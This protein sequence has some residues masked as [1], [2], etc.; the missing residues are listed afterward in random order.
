MKNKNYTKKRLLFFLV[1]IA[2]IFISVSLFIIIKTNTIRTEIEQGARS[3]GTTSY[4]TTKSTKLIDLI[5]SKKKVSLEEALSELQNEKFN[6]NN[7]LES[8]RLR[9][10][11]N[12]L[13]PSFKITNKSLE[14]TITDELT[15]IINLSR[16][17]T[18]IKRRYLG[19]KSVELGNYWITTYT[20]IGVACLL[21]ILL[22]FLGLSVFKVQQKIQ[23]LTNQ[24]IEFL[25][26]S[27]DAIIAC[28]INGNIKEFNPASEQTFGYK[29]NEVINQPVKILYSSEKEHNRVFKTIQETGYFNGEIINKRSNNETIVSNL[30]ANLIYDQKGKVMGSMGVS[31]DV[32]A[33]KKLEEEHQQIINSASDIIY[34]AN[35]KGVFTY[36]NPTVTKILGYT[37]E[38]LIGESFLSIIE[39]DFTE[40][41]ATHYQEIFKTKQAESHLEFKV[42]KKNGDP[43]WIGQNV[44]TKFDKA[45]PLKISGY[46]GI[47]RDIQDRKLAEIVLKESE[48]KYREL[49]DNSNDLILSADISGKIIYT[50]NTWKEALGYSDDETKKLNLFNIIHP[51]S[52]ADCKILFSKI[53]EHRYDPRNKINLKVFTKSGSVIILEGAISVNKKEGKIISIQ[54]FLRDATKRIEAENQLKKSEAT[55]RKITETIH[56]VFYLYNIVEKKYEYISPNCAQILGATPDFFYSGKSHTEKFAHPDDKQI[57]ISA[58]EEVD[59]GCSYDIEYRLVFNNEI[60]WINEQSFPIQDKNGNIISNSGICRD[61][62]HIKL[63]QET[64]DRQ[65]LEIESSILYAKRI[66]DSALPSKNEVKKILPESFIIYKPKEILSGDFYIVDQ[67]LIQNKY[68][69]PTFI[70]AD[71]TGHGIPGGILSLLCNRLIKESFTSTKVHS[72]GEALDLIR[73]RLNSFFRMKKTMQIQDGMDLSYCV[74]DESKKELHFSGANSSCIIIRNKEVIIYKGDRQHIGFSSKQKKFT[75][76]IINVESGDSIYLYTDGIVDQFGGPHNKKFMRK[77]LH[78]LLAKNYD[79]PME[80]QSEILQQELLTWKGSYHQTDDITILGVRIN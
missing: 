59:K 80:K 71:C 49:F 35:A 30:S 64:I 36:I 78:Q 11:L 21:M 23:L 62:T 37:P 74:L 46:Y 73:E 10:S 33:L 60:K 76:H 50:N 7:D 20:L 41:V 8:E 4:I 16:E 48:E 43:L 6:L 17:L 5:R 19:I 25:R 12:Q 26:N 3:I 54:S 28:D 66:Q 56:D 34:S 63:A 40:H 38:E 67:I 29:R 32:T 53:M 69:W 22:S 9:R 1:F 31:R 70:V 52:Q 24:N 44:K 61:I 18:S 2:I 58:N 77:R 14:D 68:L 13:N 47:V 65:N 39:K 57:L 27:K 79:A 45:D 42:I 72:P 51:D 55:F 15:S 75:T